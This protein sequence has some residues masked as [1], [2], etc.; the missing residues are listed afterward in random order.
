MAAKNKTFDLN[1]VGEEPKMNSEA[2][3]TTMEMAGFYNWYNYMHDHND[4]RKFTKQYAKDTPELAK[5]VKAI[6][7]VPMH[8]I[9]TTVGWLSRMASRGLKLTPANK[10]YIKDKLEEYEAYRKANRIV[11]S[12]AEAPVA[13]IAE[14]TF[15]KSKDLSGEVEGMIDDFVLN[16]YQEPYDVYSKMVDL[17]I[18]GA[19]AKHIVKYFK[20]VVKELT[21]AVKK[22][23]KKDD[24]VSEGYRT[25]KLSDL[26]RLSK[27]VENIV[28]TLGTIENNSKKARK[29]RKKKSKPAG[30]QVSKM[31]YMARYDDLQLVSEPA[32]NLVGAKAAFIFN[33]TNNQLSMYI[34][35]SDGF[36]VA[37]SSIKN[38]RA[39]ESQVKR[40]GKKIDVMKSLDKLTRADA[41]KAFQKVKGSSKEASGR[42]NDKMII[43]KVF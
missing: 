22:Y 6:D 18:K 26:K 23:K 20:P 1:M 28:D 19:H 33:T 5:L 2:L 7:I 41:V 14:R 37:R 10:K 36:T 39:K 12:T 40:F 42:I 35:D 4:A 31:K 15:E 30:K 24:P 9:S 3:Y 27:F 25:T 29:T 21:T 17:G 11:E 32:E 43:V 34:A 16:N 38:F 13:S 8:I